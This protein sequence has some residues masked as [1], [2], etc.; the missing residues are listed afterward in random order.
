MIWP[1]LLLALRSFGIT[2]QDLFSRMTY[3]QHRGYI[4]AVF[5]AIAKLSEFK[6]ASVVSKMFPGKE[7]EKDNSYSVDEMVGMGLFGKGEG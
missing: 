7:E 6:A 1:I 3:W 5:P 2:E 4:K